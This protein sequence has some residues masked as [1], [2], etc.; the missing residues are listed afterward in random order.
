VSGHFD[1]GCVPLARSAATIVLQAI[2][3]AVGDVRQ[4]ASGVM[5][6][7]FKVTTVSGENYIVRFYPAS[8]SHVREYEPDLLR[9]CNSL[10][11]RVP[12]VVADSSGDASTAGGYMVYKMLPGVSLSERLDHVGPQELTVVSRR[13]IDEL[14]KL[15]RL[16]ITGFGDLLNDRKAKLSSWYEFVR[17]TFD[18]GLKASHERD[19]LSQELLNSLTLIGGRLDR[20]SRPVQPT[21]AWGDLSPENVIVDLNGKFVGLIDFEGV[22]AAEFDL[23][24]GFLRARCIGTPFYNAM[25]YNWPPNQFDQPRIELYVL[26]RALRLL[27][28]SKGPLPTGV[29]RDPI[30]LFLPAFH[31]SVNDMMDWM[32][33][34]GTTE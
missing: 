13:I 19:L 29:V 16:Q 8:R 11:I 9:R 18:L 14:K 23:S 27:Q 30:E 31:S 15:S 6:Q 4:I 25:A 1:D 5:T 26:V 20:F 22:L 2:G 33:K 10:G 24:L 17:Q 28:Y 3:K 7:K 12:E 32:L 21:L 34:P